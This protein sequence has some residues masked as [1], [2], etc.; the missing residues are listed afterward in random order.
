MRATH[1]V[2]DGPG[3]QRTAADPHHADR[4]VRAAHL[5]R[6]L[7]DVLR[8]P[9]VRRQTREAYLPGIADLPE[10]LAGLDRFCEMVLDFRAGEAV[11]AHHFGREVGWIELNVHKAPPTFKLAAKGAGGTVGRGS[12]GTV[13]KGSRSVAELKFRAG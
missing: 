3:A 6:E 13:G 1:G 7:Q 12:G 4:F 10:A 11:L 9:G 2:I 8:G 5:G